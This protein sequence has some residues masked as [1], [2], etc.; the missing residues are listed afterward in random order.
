VPTVEPRSWPERN[1][2]IVAVLSPG[3]YG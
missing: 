3:R 2:V 1:F